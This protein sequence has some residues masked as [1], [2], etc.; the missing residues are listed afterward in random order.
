MFTSSFIFSVPKGPPVNIKIR[1]QTTNSLIFS[2]KPPDCQHR[3]S[4]LSDTKY[5]YK[6]WSVSW[7]EQSTDWMDITEPVVNF[8]HLEQLKGYNFR[9]RAVNQQGSGV[10]SEI[11]EAK[12]EESGKQTNMQHGNCLAN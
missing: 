10:P 5:Q 12:T 1:E 9:V 2:W 11:I 8:T 6:F 7:A 4:P 3:N